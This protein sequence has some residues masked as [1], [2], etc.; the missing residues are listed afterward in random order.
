MNREILISAI[1]TRPEAR[2]P[3]ILNGLPDSIL[4]SAVLAKKDYE[5]GK[6]TDSEY[7]LR[8]RVTTLP[9][10]TFGY[11]IYCIS[12]GDGS[13]YIGRTHQ[14][15]IDRISEH[16]GYNGARKTPRI[17]RRVNAGIP[18]RFECLVSGLS[19]LEAK[20]WEKIEI[21]NLEKP[22]NIKHTKTFSKALFSSGH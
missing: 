21:N 20:I 8:S 14:W 19:E 22:L 12:F 15:I 13:A 4:V 11:S 10:E 18:Y 9:N 2:S 6:I 3:V 16:F 1:A 7:L 17:M 5:K